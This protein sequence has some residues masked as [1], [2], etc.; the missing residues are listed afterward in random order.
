MKNNT[1]ILITLLYLFLS[2]FFNYGLYRLLIVDELSNQ[3]FFIFFYFLAEIITFLFFLI[4]KSKDKIITNTLGPIIINDGS[5]DISM[6]SGTDNN[7]TNN[8]TT[9]LNITETRMS[10]IQQQP[11]IGMKFISFLIPSV[12]DF[13]SKFFTFNGLKIIGNE[14]IFR[15][16]IQLLTISLISKFILKSKYNKFSIT[17][18]YVILSGLIISCVFYQIFHSIKLYVEF[19]SHGIVGMILC[20]F[21]EIFSSIQIFFQ[22]K[23]FKIGEK[24]CYREI[25][26]EGLFGLIISFLFFELSILIPCPDNKNNNEIKNT[27]FFCYKNSSFK[28][29]EFLLDN[30][31][32]NIVWNIIFFLTGIFYNL[33]GAIL[34]KYIGEIYR[35]GVDVGRISIIVYLILF[36][37]SEKIS[38]LSVILSTLFM[39]IIL[40]GII[41]CIILRKQKDITFD[42]LPLDKSYSQ[43]LSLITD[44]DNSNI[45][46][47]NIEI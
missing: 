28:P 43:D 32:N 9:S 24:Y 1:L 44:E 6:I 40:F 34:S 29:F 31:K 8:L 10:S 30:I 25:A 5:I 39:V 22:M 33:V 18:I 21:G 27:F 41:L 15:S 35:T 47:S 4:P 45:N 42:T 3:Y 26:W 2:I 11:F 37:H 7:L 23:Y 17:G 20:I 46:E 19:N 14:I 12:F 13:L 16:I 36:V 38:L